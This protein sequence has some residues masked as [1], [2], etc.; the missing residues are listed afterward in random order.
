MEGKLQ[1]HH[2]F[3]WALPS[4]FFPIDAVPIQTKNSSGPEGRGLESWL[5][6][7]EKDPCRVSQRVTALARAV[8]CIN[9]IQL[10]GGREGREGRE[11]GGGTE[12]GKAA[13][14]GLF[15]FETTPFVWFEIGKGQPTWVATWF[16]VLTWPKRIDRV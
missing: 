10:Q 8:R 14:F 9:C 3:S 4:H 6:P 1:R 15:F 16:D 13:R 2:R 5:G 11:R 7:K 12:L